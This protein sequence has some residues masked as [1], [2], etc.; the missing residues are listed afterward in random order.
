[1]IEDSSSPDID[2][3]LYSRQIG[4]FG[5]EAMGKLIKLRVFIQGMS[6]VSTK[7]DFREITSILLTSQDWSGN[8]KKSHPRWSKICDHS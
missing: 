6:G 4:A 8:R 7:L 2:H 3:N 5:V 1:M